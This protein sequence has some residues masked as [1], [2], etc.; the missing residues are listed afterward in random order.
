MNLLSRNVLLFAPL[1]CFF[2]YDYEN[3]K[4][5]ESFLSLTAQCFVIEM[6]SFDVHRCVIYFF[7]LA[8]IVQMK[9]KQHG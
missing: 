7:N 4:Y 6:F 3:K 5:F 1:S 9:I 8:S 2:V